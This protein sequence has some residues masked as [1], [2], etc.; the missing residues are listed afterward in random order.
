MTPELLQFFSGQPEQVLA[1][2]YTGALI[3]VCRWWITCKT[4]LDKETMLREFAGI[5]EKMM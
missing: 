2:A 5:M 1:Q 4:A 3:Y